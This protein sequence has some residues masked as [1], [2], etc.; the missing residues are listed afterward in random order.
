MPTIS[1]YVDVDVDLDDFDTD[2]LIE[3]LESRGH[4]TSSD[5]I[6]EMDALDKYEIEYL[7]DL[8]DKSE[9]RDYNY[10]KIREKLNNLRWGPK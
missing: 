6:P 1:T 4:Y 10:Y 9:K 5:P 8:L 7:T 2:E 3:E